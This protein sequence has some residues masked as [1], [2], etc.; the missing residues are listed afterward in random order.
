MFDIYK[1]ADYAQIEIAKF[2]LLHPNEHFYGFA[3]YKYLLCLNSEEEFQEELMSLRKSNPDMC[4]TENQV[5]ELKKYGSGYWA[6]QGFDDDAKKFAEFSESNGF[7]EECYHR[8]YDEN[9]NRIS[10][11]LPNSALSLALEDS[12]DDY[13]KAMRNVLTLLID[14]NAFSPLNRTDDFVASFEATLDDD[15]DENERYY[16]TDDD[17][18]D[19]DWENEPYNCEE[20]KEILDDFQQYHIDNFHQ[21]H[22]RWIYV[23]IDQV[24][25]ITSRLRKEVAGLSDQWSDEALHMYSEE[26]KKHQETGMS[27]ADEIDNSNILFIINGYLHINIHDIRTVKMIIEKIDAI[28]ESLDLYEK[29]T[30]EF[31]KMIREVKERAVWHRANKALEKNLI[32]KAIGLL[33]QDWILAFQY[34]PIPLITVADVIIEPMPLITVADVTIEPMPLITVADVTIEPTPLITVPDVIIQTIS[35]VFS[36]RPRPVRKQ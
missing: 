35:K 21:Y 31:K 11:L 19:D 20:A 8:Y 4:E 27:L 32:N 33:S 16:Y 36:T 23:S 13:E 5:N 18:E 9:L 29:L 1:M 15:F 12:S 25:D 14:R 2:A 28:Y 17:F 22:I 7:D 10:N 24:L 6:Y 3:I 26:L 34:E 30:D